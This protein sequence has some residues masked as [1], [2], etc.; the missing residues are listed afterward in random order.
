MYK[1]V[2]Y[3]WILMSII[4]AVCIGLVVFYEVVEETHTLAE[5]FTIGT[6]GFFLLLMALFYRLEVTVDH[7]RINLVFGIGIIRKSIPLSDIDKVSPVRNKFWYGWGI[8]LTPHGWLWNISGYE[9]V[10]LILKSNN[11]KFRIGCIDGKELSKAI[12]KAK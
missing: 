4:G 12:K 8:R 10:E 2:Q 9:A 3:G 5:P 7:Q 11:R 6:I 1:K